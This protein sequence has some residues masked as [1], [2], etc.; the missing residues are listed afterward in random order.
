MLR[1]ISL[2]VSLPVR[3]MLSSNPAHASARADAIEL[4]FVGIG[5]IVLPILVILYK[6]INSQRERMLKEDGRPAYSE[7]QL[8]EMGDKAP[9][10]RY[11][12]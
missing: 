2:V 9:D 8:K 3:G 5:F 7:Q 10:F 11:T 6:N 4:M 1:V 12:I